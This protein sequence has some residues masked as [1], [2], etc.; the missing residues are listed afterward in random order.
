MIYLIDD[1]KLRQEKDFGWTSEKLKSN[2]NYITPIYTLE[3]LENIKREIFINTNTVIYH[4]SFLDNTTLEKEAALRRDKLEKFAEENESFNLVIFSG[5]KSSRTINQN[6]AHVPV[7]IV[8]Q[9]LD[10]FIKKTANNELDINYL[11]FG[12]NPNI[13]NEL[14]NKLEDSLIKLENA[15]VKIENQT[16]LFITTPERDIQNPIESTVML[17]LYDEESDENI[18]K[19][20]TNNLEDSKYDIIFI[21]LCYGNSLSDFNGLRL[22]A[23]IRCTSGLNQLTRIFIYGFVGFEFLIQNKYFNILKTKNVNLVGFSKQDFKNAAATINIPLT[24]EELPAE[25]EKLKLDP[26]K[27]YYDSHGIANEWAIH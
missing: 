14:L 12:N 19:F 7:S 9:N 1:K 16:S 2:K 17:T 23:H 6:I 27:N 20:I 25:M 15:P 24:M 8:Y 26:P 11:A 10:V 13:E 22:A 18:S 21:P 5:S 3:E 4:E